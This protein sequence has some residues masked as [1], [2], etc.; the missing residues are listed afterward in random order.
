MG[1]PVQLPGLPS[2]TAANDADVTLL[3]QGLTDY[4]CSLALI[5]NINVQNL[6]YLPGTVA[7]ND[8]ILVSR[9]VA[10]VPTNFKVSFSAIGFAAG[11]MCWFY[12]T[13]A[14]IA[15]SLPG[16]SIVPN[17]GDALLACKGGSTYVTANTQLGDWQQ[18]D[19]TLDLSQIPSH[20]HTINIYQNSAGGLSK[21]YCM[22]ANTTIGNSAVGTAINY[23][24]GRTAEP[25]NPTGPVQLDDTWRPLANVGYIAVK[26]V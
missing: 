1:S 7:L 5:R 10:S 14:Q 26:N 19:F 6:T 20:T 17:T 23:E 8:Q 4:Q 11:T 15:S 13:S 16:W 12:M 22:G 2:A 21:N 18:P 3:R 9:V 24:G 25:G